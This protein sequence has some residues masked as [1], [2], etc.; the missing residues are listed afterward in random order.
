MPKLDGKSDEAKRSQLRR[1]L[2]I[3]VN[4]TIAGASGLGL[5]IERRV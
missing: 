3:A 2:L 1:D 4:A 5:N